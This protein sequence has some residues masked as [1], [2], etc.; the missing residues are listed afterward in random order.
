MLPSALAGAILVL[1]ADI[2]VRVIGSDQ[3]LRLGVVTALVGAP[4]FLWL[5]MQL[6]RGGR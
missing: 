5:L 6:K 3:E 4:F 2:A 1:A